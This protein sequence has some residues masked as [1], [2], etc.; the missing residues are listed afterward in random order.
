MDDRTG[1]AP[2]PALFLNGSP[3]DSGAT[4]SIPDTLTMTGGPG[5]IYYT[6]DGTDPRQ[7]FTGNALGTAY[8]GGITL[9]KT[10]DVRARIKN[11]SSWSA[12]NRAVFAD[13]RPLNNLRI[14]EIMYHPQTAGEEYL[15]LQNIGATSINLYLCEFTD[16]IR[17]TFPDMTLAGGQHVLVV[18]NQAAFEARH[19]PGHNIAGEF[20][21]GSAL[22][23]GGE[24]IVL[25]DAA[26]REIHDFDYS[27]WYPITDGR[28]ASLSIIDPTHADLT[29]WDQKAGWQ[30][31]SALGGSPGAVNPANVVTNGSIVINEILTHT[32]M[33]GG[34]W[35]ELRNTTA[36]PIDIGGWFLSDNLDDLK[37]YQI[38]SGTSIPG[39]GYHVFNQEANFGLTA[40]DPG[41]LTGFGLS[42]LG[43]SVYLSSGFGTNLGGGYSVSEDFGASAKEVTLGRYTKSAASGYGVDFVPMASATMGTANSGPLVPDVVI[44]QI[45]YNP[46]L[47]H[48]EV[49]EYIELFNRSS[50]T[51]NLHDPDN[52]SNTWKFTQ[53]I[54]YTFPP[55]VSVPAGARVLVVRTDPDVFRYV[56]SIPASRPI[57]GPYMG[58]L[59]N[60][61]EKLE[62]SMPGD[63]EAGFVPYIATEKVNFSD[64][65]HPAGSDPWPSAA[66]GTVGYSLHRTVAGDYGNDVDNWVAGPPTPVTPNLNMIELQQTEGSTYLLWAADG[67]LQSAPQITGPW[68]NV[69]GATSPYQ[70]TIGSQPAQ[71]FRLEATA[72][73]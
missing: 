46:S 18:E 56:H 42:E 57:Y 52:P 49:A 26:G 38:A 50:R 3:A 58:A 68:T 47:N 6:L 2:P 39:G 40:A 51:I 61:G 17:F 21:I 73:P 31:S 71:Y 35:I 53:G 14:T 66:D 70:M 15:E 29:L 11:G 1:A 10:V 8:T 48:D 44:N 22:N 13:D 43:E 60:D 25:R 34:D 23:N 5:T 4:I 64:G 20:K 63:P 12:M 9:N 32:D 16:G 59:G 69:S 62:L 33:P 36:S 37:K 24:E 54:D 65:S 27:D 19:G 67:M 41:R 45:M 28:G 7:A 72:G 55:G 30:A